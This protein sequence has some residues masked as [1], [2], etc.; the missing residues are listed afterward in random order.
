M[1]TYHRKR[2]KRGST[3]EAANNEMISLNRKETCSVLHGPQA[4]LSRQPLLD[5]S[6]EVPDEEVELGSVYEV[7][8]MYLPPRTPAQL[9][10]T[11]VVM[12]S[13]KTDLNVAIRYPSVSSIKTYFGGGI[14]EMYPALDE[15]FVMG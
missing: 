3:F 6:Y 4:P 7:N 15:K 5:P 12:V 2:P 11:R 8:H 1:E 14:T 10:S 9:R 13:E